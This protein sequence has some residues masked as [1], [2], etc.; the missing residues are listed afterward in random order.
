MN[1]E[2]DTGEGADESYSE[3][4]AGESAE[5]DAGEGAEGDANDGAD[6]VEVEGLEQKKKKG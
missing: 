4:D 3:W 5:G 6:V 1:S 2:E